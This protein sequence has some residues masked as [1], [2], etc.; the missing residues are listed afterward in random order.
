[1]DRTERFYKIDRLL[2]QHKVLG[3]SALQAA[4]ETSRS[5]LKRDLEYLRTRLNRPIEWS[6]D[7]GGYRVASTAEHADAAQE[8]PGLWLSANEMR[9]LLT[10]HQLLT[11]LDSGGLL[12]PHIAPLMTRINAMLG[13]GNH[14][15]E[16]IT[17][18]VRII[19]LANRPVQ[20]EN[21]QT[22]SAALLQRKRLNITYF[23]RGSR[24]TT[25]REVSPLRLVHYRENWHLDAWCHLRG[26]LRNFALD[27]VMD[28]HVLDATSKEVS[29][30][31]LD[32][33]FGP[34]YGIFAGKRVHQA[35]LRFA[36]DKAPWVKTQQWHPHQQGQLESDGSYLLRLPYADHRELIMDILKYGA[37]CEVLGPPS[38]R[39]AVKD[40]VKAM[41]KKYF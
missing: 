24:K 14:D 18:R 41:S 25:Q 11:G 22:I 9:S 35:R 1:M 21:F 3:F 8:L 6:R 4:L 12:A 10:M 20:P 28:A 37:G 39:K 15:A 29:D 23:S 26:S 13:S 40:E 7:A 34:G 32:A 36:P 27:A 31:R 16:Q 2:R 33:L 17:R 30:A 38:L 19:A 5:T